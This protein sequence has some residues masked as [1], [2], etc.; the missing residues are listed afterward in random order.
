MSGLLWV[1]VAVALLHGSARADSVFQGDVPSP[2]QLLLRYNAEISLALGAI[3]SLRV[4]QNFLEPQEDGSFKT[5]RAVLT[6]AAGE[7]VERQIVESEISHMFGKY[8]LESLVGPRIELSEYEVALEGAEEKDGH[9]CYRLAIEALVRDADH[10]DGTIWI[11]RT[12]PGPVRIVGEVAD[13]PFPLTEIKLDKSFELQPC[14][15]WLVR[16]HT[17]EAEVSLF[18]RRSGTRHIFYDGYEIRLAD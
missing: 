17:G 9:D 16:R 3:E 6:Y 12:H 11:S 15:L 7:G 10:F 2:D 5:A 8:T 4:E 1:T 13:P 18:G 14:G